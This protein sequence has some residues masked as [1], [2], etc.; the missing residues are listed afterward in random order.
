MR[1]EVWK[2]GYADMGTA[3]G[4]WTPGFRAPF[5]LGVVP[6]GWD[7]ARDSLI[8]KGVCY[9]TDNGAFFH[10][11][12]T[13]TDTDQTYCNGLS[14]TP[15]LVTASSMMRLWQLGV[16][17][18]GS[19]FPDFNLGRSE[20]DVVTLEFAV[21][22][23]EGEDPVALVRYTVGGHTAAQ[24]LPEKWRGRRLA[25]AIA[26]DPGTRVTVLD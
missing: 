4:A 12:V 16:E 18:H 25:F 20:I 1:L 10:S 26:L 13:V 9:A 23:R 3:P 7:F 11:G 21:E 19:S 2:L 22:Q 15:A 24:R 14:F 17:A 5:L 6:E 8:Q